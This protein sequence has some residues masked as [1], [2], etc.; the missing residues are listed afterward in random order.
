MIIK[1]IKFKNL[2]S[3]GNIITEYD[4][5]NPEIVFIT[6]KNGAGKTSLLDAIYFNLVGKPFRD[7]KIGQLINSKN[8]KE[9][10]TIGEYKSST[11]TD[12]KIIRGRKNDI[13]ELYIN[14]EKQD[15][16]S[17]SDFQK[18]I[19][20]ILEFSP[21]NLEKLF[22]ISTTS[23]IP[24]LSST[25]DVKRKLIDQ[26]IEIESFSKMSDSIKK[27]R[28]I[29]KENLKSIEF[30]IEKLKS[31]IDLIEDFNKKIESNKNTND[32]IE[33]QEIDKKIEEIK[34][35]ANKVK[36]EKD[37]DQTKLDDLTDSLNKS[38]QKD[39][40]QSKAI[41]DL[42]SKIYKL[43]SQLDTKKEIEQNKSVFFNENK[44]CETCEQEINDDHK[45]QITWKIEQKILKL[46]SDQI[47]IINFNKKL[48]LYKQKN[49]ETKQIINNNQ[50][51]HQY[52]SKLLTEHGIKQ[53][54]LKHEYQLLSQKKSGLND[55]ISKQIEPKDSG[56]LIKDLNNQYELKL[57]TVRQLE[58]IEKSIEML[59][60]KYLRAH[61]IEKYLPI[62]NESLN[63]YLD[64]F[65]LSFKIQLDGEFNEEMLSRDYESLSY[66]SLSEGEKLRVNMALIFSF[67]DVSK[68]RLKETSNVL[69]LDE[70][71]SSSIDQEG[72]IG[73]AQIISE[74]KES[75]ISV[76]IIAHTDLNDVIDFDKHLFIEKKNGF[77]TIKE[78]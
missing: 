5:S 43:Q 52:I 13:F 22:L 44:I 41:I 26:L 37:L 34:V 27:D 19:E 17:S 12:V 54:N 31:N 29:E 66:K 11:G 60:E 14:D 36:V 71:F 3:Y 59:G 4:F 78:I 23:Y 49:E 73:L 15:Q 74:L 65:G 7:I 70:I 68:V 58:I 18:R 63:K 39:L 69:V 21:N 6:G 77:S 32:E 46:D 1:N 16:E 72:M 50:K 9:L 24:F 20:T 42:Q 76:I 10:L 61:C 30:Q 48:N 64:I 38:I 55:V 25:P 56:P 33:I 67:F 62:I 40:D 28:T 51:T 57:K 45:K 35:E 47:E 53:T 75:N 8:K 2:L